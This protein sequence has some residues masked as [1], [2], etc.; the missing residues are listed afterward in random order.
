M[1]NVAEF[2][3]GALSIPGTDGEDIPACCFRCVYLLTKE[4]SVNP[5][6]DLF[7]YFCAYNWPDKITD[8]VPPCLEKQA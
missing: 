3:T 7:Y 6:D 8:T 4:F 1:I 5:N 2:R